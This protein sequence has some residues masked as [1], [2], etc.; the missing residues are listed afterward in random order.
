M[1]W[2]DFEYPWTTLRPASQ[3]L[4]ERYLLAWVAEAAPPR[5]R[6]LFVFDRGCARVELIKELNR[7]P[8]PYL[9]RGKGDVIVEATVR[10][11]GRGLR[12]GRLPHRTGVPMRYRHVLYHGQQQE[13]V[14]VIVYRGPGFQDAWFLIVPPDSEAWLPTEEVIRLDAERI[15]IEHCFPDWKSQLGLRGLHLELERTSR[16]LRLLMAF[17]LAYP[18]TLL[19]GQDP[20]AEKARAYFEQPRRTPRD[21]TRRV[22]SV[23]SIALYLLADARWRERALRRF[24]QIVTPLRGRRGVPL[25]PVFSP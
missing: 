6:L 24:Q 4:A 13:P 10:G 14:D 16:L 22:L 15:E 20:L 3:N 18:L 9:I 8:Q 2:V 17:T 25:P 12:L 7:W 5:A 1:A 19:L 23:L 11:R 21:G